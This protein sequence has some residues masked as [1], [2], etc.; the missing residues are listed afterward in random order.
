MTVSVLFDNVICELIEEAGVGFL[1]WLLC[2][3]RSIINNLKSKF[4]AVKMNMNKS[5]SKAKQF[6]A[7][8]KNKLTNAMLALL[9]SSV[10][11]LLSADNAI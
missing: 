3:A 2:Y 5:I 4:N 11:L 1:A 10:V 8:N 6:A 7:N 9:V